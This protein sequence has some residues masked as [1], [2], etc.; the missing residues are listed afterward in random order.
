LGWKAYFGLAQTPKVWPRLD[1]W[2]GHR[3]RA[4]QLKHWKTGPT[5]HR[6]LLA[7]GAQAAVAHRVAANSRRCQRNSRYLLNSILTI[8]YFD[9]PG[10]PRLS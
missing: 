5:I 1:E 3:M 2:M 7:L 8:A 6:E 4:I 10:M 9:R